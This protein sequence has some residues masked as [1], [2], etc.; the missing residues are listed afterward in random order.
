MTSTSPQLHRIDKFAV[1]AEAMT[2][3]LT[4]VRHTH[5]ILGGQPGIVRNDVVTLVDGES[6]YNVVTAVT[7]ESREALQNAGRAV[8]A[9]VAASGFDRAAFLRRLGVTADFGTYS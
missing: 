4:R 8:A 6:D 9:D 7:W 2:E 5:R 1:P 3:F